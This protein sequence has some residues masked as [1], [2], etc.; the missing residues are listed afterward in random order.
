M[1][2]TMKNDFGCDDFRKVIFRELFTC[3]KFLRYSYDRRIK[4]IKISKFWFKAIDS[5]WLPPLSG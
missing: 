3:L 4:S 2:C 1:L 5:S